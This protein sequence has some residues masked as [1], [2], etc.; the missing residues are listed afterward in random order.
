M[1]SRCLAGWRL[2]RRVPA[3]RRC[4]QPTGLVGVTSEPSRL[5]VSPKQSQ[6]RHH[7]SQERYSA[8]YGWRVPPPLGGGP[9]QQPHVTSCR[10]MSLLG[11]RDTT[12]WHTLGGAVQEI[13]TIYAPRHGAKHAL[14]SCGATRGGSTPPVRILSRPGRDVSGHRR[15]AK[16]S[17][18]GSPAPLQG[19]FCISRTKL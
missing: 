13:A 16:W 3:G 9:S 8:N 1:D 14:G 4:L 12:G 11:S 19:G 17:S 2:E 18:L 15:K 7:R 5:W 10:R 6:C